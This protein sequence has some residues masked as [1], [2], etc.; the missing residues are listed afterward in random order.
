MSDSY[1]LHLLVLLL[2]L[3]RRTEALERFIVVL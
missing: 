3:R 1:F 2:L